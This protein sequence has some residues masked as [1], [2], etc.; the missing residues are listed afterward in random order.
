[1]PAQVVIQVRRDIGSTWTLTNPVLALGEIGFDTTENSIKIGDGESTWTALDYASGASFQISTSAPVGPSV[2]DLWFDPDDSAA[3]IRAT[4]TGASSATW[5]RLNP[6]LGTN[7]VETINIKDRN[8]T[9]DK[10]ALGA[11]IDRIAGKRIL[12]NPTQPGTPTGGWNVGD[13]WISY[14]P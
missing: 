11:T 7:D 3:Y 8:V 2:G 10:L 12:V 5:V 6:P 14:T 13:V 9:S 1:M 4:L